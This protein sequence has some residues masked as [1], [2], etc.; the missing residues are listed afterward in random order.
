MS[1]MQKIFRKVDG[2]EKMVLEFKASLIAAKQT[3]NG[4]QSQVLRGSLKIYSR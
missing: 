3:Q 1:R 2:I 4:T